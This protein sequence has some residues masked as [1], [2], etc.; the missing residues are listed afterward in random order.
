MFLGPSIFWESTPF[1]AESRVILP[2]NRFLQGF[3]SAL[4]GKPPAKGKPL[5]PA[6]TNPTSTSSGGNPIPPSFGG[7]PPSSGGNPTPLV[8]DPIPECSREP[9]TP[10]LNATFVKDTVGYAMTPVDPLIEADNYNIHDLH[11]EDSTDD[12]EFPKKV[13][14]LYYTIHNCTM[15]V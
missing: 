7:I 12:D 5:P 15:T 14:P 3:Y 8:L 6:G 9:V 4:K 2:A 10:S 13:E 1:G 11:S